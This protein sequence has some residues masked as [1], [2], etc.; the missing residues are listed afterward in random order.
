TSAVGRDI[1]SIRSLSRCGNWCEGLP[2]IPNTKQL[3]PRAV[4]EPH[5]G[6]GR[7]GDA[8]F[9]HVVGGQ[10]RHVGAVGEHGD[11]AIVANDVDLAVA[12]DRLGVD[13]AG[14]VNAVLVGEAF[15][16][17]D[18][19]VAGEAAAFN[20]EQAIVDEQG[21][22]QGVGG[23]VFQLPENVGFADVSGAAGFDRLDGGFILE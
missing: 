20:Q 3:L 4:I 13:R 8:V 9:A 6:N 15:A 10:R 23:A 11:L 14:D 17:V 22:N 1:W 5:V 21:R 2:S 12:V 16:L 7:G 18:S 19:E